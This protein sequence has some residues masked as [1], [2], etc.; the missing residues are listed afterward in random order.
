[1]VER[2]FMVA[3]VALGLAGCAEC[4][5][6]GCDALRDRAP[7]RQPGIGGIIASQSDVV[8]NGCEECGFAEAS[9]E[10]FRLKEPV[11]SAEAASAAIG[12]TSPLVK[13]VASARYNAPLDPGAYLVCVAR[14]CLSVRVMDGAVTTVNI[15]QR[16]GPTS[17]FVVDPASNQLHE[18]FGFEQVGQEP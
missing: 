14:Q 5:T 17:F 18:Q 4:P 12:M 2:V 9:I 15:K 7:G 1:M 3:M 16:F 8:V 11:T 10:V 6:E 13:L